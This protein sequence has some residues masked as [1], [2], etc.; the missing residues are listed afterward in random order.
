MKLF[1]KG[2][3]SMF[4]QNKMY[5]FIDSIFFQRAFEFTTSLSILLIF[6]FSCN[7]VKK[8]ECPESLHQYSITSGFITNSDVK[9]IKG[10]KV[11]NID[12]DLG[13]DNS[14]ELL[15]ILD[16]KI[17]FVDGVKINV[18]ILSYRK[19]YLYHIDTK[20][21]N[22][23]QNEIKYFIAYC[24]M[25]HVYYS[26]SKNCELAR[27]EDKLEWKKYIEKIQSKYLEKAEKQ[28]EVRK[29]HPKNKKS[30]ESLN[31]EHLLYLENTYSDKIV[32]KYKNNLDTIKNHQNFTYKVYVPKGSVEVFGY[33]ENGLEMFYFNESIKEKSIYIFDSEGNYVKR[34][35]SK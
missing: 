18:P 20:N 11:I 26:P 33:R 5:N 30:G 24:S 10:D 25:Y 32:V 9:A 7:K 29:I 19:K 21:S 6:L 16:K 22:I 31:R 23:S 13:K 1:I 3:F 17:D 15:S 2:W 8:C 14:N 4:L 12:L 34:L 27:V 35:L 28:K